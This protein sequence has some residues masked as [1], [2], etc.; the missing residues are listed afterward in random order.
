M[1]IEDIVKDALKGFDVEVL[2][3]DYPEYKCKCSKA[4][5]EATLKSLGEKELKSMCE[6]L[7]Q[8][9][10]KCHFCNTEYSFSKK[11]IEKILKKI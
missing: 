4:K 1:D 5:V 2:Y 10:V 9:D 6:D 8:V 11:D 3:T 7:P